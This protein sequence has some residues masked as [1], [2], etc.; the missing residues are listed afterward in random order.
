MG[1]FLSKDGGY[2]LKTVDRLT[3]P[4][5]VTPTSSPCSYVARQ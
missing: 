1:N 4:Q 2:Q 3:K 5:I